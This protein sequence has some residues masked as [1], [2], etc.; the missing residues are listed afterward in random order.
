MLGNTRGEE[1]EIPVR[2]GVFIFDLHAKLPPSHEE[3]LGDIIK[4]CFLQSQNSSALWWRVARWNGHGRSSATSHGKT[5][6]LVYEQ[7][8]AR[9]ALLG[10]HPVVFLLIVSGALLNT[11]LC[12]EAGITSRCHAHRFA[13]Y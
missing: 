7:P 8:I 4:C 9:F 11:A 2:A 6:V 3:K 5:V 10:L 1:H 12:F 13:L